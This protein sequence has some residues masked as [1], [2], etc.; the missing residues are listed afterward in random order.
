MEKRPSIKT[1][2]YRLS[3]RIVL[4]I[5]LLLFAG[6]NKEQGV[7]LSNT[8][9]IIK[10]DRNID[11]CNQIDIQDHLNLILT[12]T[13]PGTIT[14]EGGKNIIG[15]IKTE[16][17][18]GILYLSNENKCNWLRDYGIPIN[19]YV[20]GE[21]IWRIVYNSSGNVSTTKTLTYDSLKVEIWGGC[22]VVDLSVSLVKGMFSLNM[23]TADLILRGN[24]DEIYLYAG[25][26]GKFDGISLVTKWAHAVNKSSNDSYIRVESATDPTTLLEATILSIGNI[27]YT[28]NPQTIKADVRGSGNVIP[29]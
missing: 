22:G 12:D 24:S 8:G 11:S 23:G 25:S 28:G 18:D 2:F 21:G 20:S 17:V 5:L 10:Q 26:Y 13:P 29:F 3:V 1:L 7:C 14:V 6:C 16:V 27:Y 4:P 19:V 15:G 9:P